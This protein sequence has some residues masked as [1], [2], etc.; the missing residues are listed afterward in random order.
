VPQVASEATTYAIQ[1]SL[2]NPARAAQ[3]SD[4]AQ[5]S[6]FASLLDDGPQASSEQP[7]QSSPASGDKTAPTAGPDSAQP[8]VKGSDA[9]QSSNNANSVA[10]DILAA[11]VTAASAGIAV[12][13]DQASVDAKIS[14]QTAASDDA[15]PAGDGKPTDGL[16]PA[17][18]ATVAASDLIPT[19]MTVAAV[20]P[21]PG[22]IAP[23][24]PA[25]IPQPAPAAVLQSAPG[26]GAQDEPAAVP[27]AARDGVLQAAPATVPQ[28]AP[29]GVLQ[30]APATVPPAAPDGVLQ[31]APAT[32]PPAVP[33]GVLQAAS[34]TVP[35]AA[36]A[37]NH[38]A[39]VAAASP[40]P[41]S[42]ELTDPQT[43]IG[44]ATEDSNSP[45][46]SSF[47][48]QGN[49]KPQPIAADADKQAVTHPHDEV[50][51]NTHH[52]VAAETPP[53]IAA[54]TQTAMPKMAV[55]AVQQASLTAPSHDVSP[56]PA[57]PAAPAAPA[58][59]AAV[60]SLSGVA[61]EIAGQALAG[62]NRFEIR[63]DPPE[64]GRIEVRLDVDRY[65]QV[66]SSLIVDRSDTLDL[67][68]RD[69]AGLERALQDAGLKTSDNG[70]QF[71][72][73]DQS[74]DRDQG[75]APTPGAAQLVVSDD[76]F[77]AIDAIPR[78]YGRLAGLGGGIDIRV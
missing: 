30:A 77:A 37:A 21:A 61:I 47:A 28:A 39:V 58:A 69:S 70:L 40:K 26:G 32:V 36:P 57:N 59:Q 44:K 56:A 31:A 14:E 41:K 48:L 55:D 60:V 73:R 24:A 68:R 43:D 15:K 50:A 72:L 29:G 13:A 74:T 42:V 38:P 46:K 34:A 5:D 23:A 10:A 19:I 9:V 63:L 6:P 35:Q 1:P 78:N 4:H 71:S 66:T 17:D 11:I 53:A 25:A 18:P 64:L 7:P 45:A 52:T 33:D 49:G 76:A 54:D 22:T 75:N 67:L 27:Q 16:T 65:G 3:N 51:A 20:A 62:K 8:P 12:G 2:P